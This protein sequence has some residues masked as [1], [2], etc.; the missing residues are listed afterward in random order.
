MKRQPTPAR[1]G[2]FS[3]RH[4]LHGDTEITVYDDAPDAV[5]AAAVQA[6]RE[7]LRP[8]ELRELVCKA[9]RTFPDKS[10]WSEY[11]NIW[12]EVQSL[13]TG[14]AWY[15]VYDVIETVSKALGEEYDD[16]INAVF[17]E[18]GVGW[19][20]HDGVVSVRGDLD[21]EDALRRGAKALV[22]TG[23]KG[24]ARELNEAR[25]HLSR[26]PTPDLTGAVHHAFAALEAV[27]RDLD[28]GSKATLGELV[29]RH[30]AALG[31]PQPLDGAIE[32]LWGFASERARHGREGPPPAREDVE[33]VVSL[34]GSIIT[35]LVGVQ[36]R[37]PKGET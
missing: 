16:E 5:R 17:A 27:A 9:L 36:R 2:P 29:K 32:K 24:A 12:D 18:Q 7:K 34:S 31:I 19:Q 23:R 22:D 6:A 14:C 33:L 15:R 11:P 37:Q 26:R 4:D 10:N 21:F 35:Y 1:K 25:S 28:G 30:A 8:S 3:R 13:I 20:V